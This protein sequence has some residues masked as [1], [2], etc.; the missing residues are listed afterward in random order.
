MACYVA[1]RKM[2]EF[3]ELANV[4]QFHWAP[5]CKEFAHRLLSQC[6][7]SGETPM[8]GFPSRWEH[9]RDSSFWF[10]SFFPLPAIPQAF[11]TALNVPVGITALSFCP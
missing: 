8:S 1:P 10:F 4:W 3:I 7:L 5:G 9:R 11:L 6:G 2:V